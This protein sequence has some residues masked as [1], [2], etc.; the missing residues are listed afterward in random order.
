MKTLEKGKDKI[1]KICALLREETLQPAQKQAQEII[2]AANKEVEEIIANGH[3]EVDKLLDAAR[4]AI[5]KERNVFHAS[6]KQ[7]A[8]QSLEALRQAVEEKFFNERLPILLE[9]NTADPRIIADL[10]SAII[11]ALEKEGLAVNLEA[12]IPK[13]VDVKQVNQL[14]LQEVLDELKDHSVKVGNFR[15]GAQVKLE[16]KKLTLDITSEALKE[17]LST[18]VVRKD[19]RKMIFSE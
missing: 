18:Y 5:E 12:L 8:K 16:G 17:L 6:L 14:L 1:E 3:K 10:I 11:K 9:K 2:E 15:G 7:A 4:E 13:I 19:F